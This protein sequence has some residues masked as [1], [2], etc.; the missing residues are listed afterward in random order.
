MNRIPMASPSAASTASSASSSSGDDSVN[1]DLE[2]RHRHAAAAATASA[3][4][5]AAAAAERHRQELGRQ[6][7]QQLFMPL[8]MPQFRRMTPQE[9]LMATLC[10]IDVLVKEREALIG[11]LVGHHQR[12]SR[13]K[14]IG[15]LEDFS[16][17]IDR[18]MR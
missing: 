14:E 1:L 4:P 12:L 17:E 13:K 2:R 5:A 10:G 3:N 16:A 18:I 7:N 15:R 11:Q 6:L 9:D 8:T